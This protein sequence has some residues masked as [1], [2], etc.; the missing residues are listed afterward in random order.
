MKGLMLRF[1]VLVLTMVSA[2]FASAAGS[3]GEVKV[4]QV[5]VANNYVQ[6]F[7]E[8]AG[9]NPDGC[10]SAASVVVQSSHSARREIYASAMAALNARLPSYFD[11]DGC[12]TVVGVGSVP[13]VTTITVGER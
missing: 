9:S 13:V 10:S 8:N 5:K 1:G 6:V 12:S 7:F 2:S 11:V 3:T 4:R